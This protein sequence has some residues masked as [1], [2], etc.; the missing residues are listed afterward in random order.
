MYCMFSVIVLWITLV[1]SAEWLAVWL[2]RSSS[3]MPAARYHLF[4][5]MNV[6]PHLDSD[7]SSLYESLSRHGAD[8]SPSAHSRKY[9][10]R[11]TY[12]QVFQAAWDG[13][14]GEQCPHIDEICISSVATLSS[15]SEADLFKANIALPCQSGKWG[16]ESLGTYKK[17]QNVNIGLIWSAH[18]RE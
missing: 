10:P 14:T 13:G 4:S 15:S 16:K 3:E 5:R 8:A 7:V 11:D 2:I 1:L 12:Y 9:P 18:E 6:P 17:L